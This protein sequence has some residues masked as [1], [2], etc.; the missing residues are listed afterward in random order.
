MMKKYWFPLIFCKIKRVW[1]SFIYFRYQ[2]KDRLRD[3]SLKRS[4]LDNS[5]SWYDE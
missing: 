3:D 5:E 2:K 1:E 4:F